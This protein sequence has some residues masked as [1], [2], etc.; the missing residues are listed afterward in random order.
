MATLY[1]TEQ[2]SVLGKEG[3]R[4]VVRKDDE[5]LADVPIIKID[6]VV[7]FGNVSLSTPA[8]GLLMARDVDVV[9]LSL[10]GRYKG[11]LTGPG[12]GNGALRQAQYRRSLD[13]DFALRTARAIVRAKLLNQ[14]ALLTWAGQVF[15][16][17][18]ALAD[19]LRRI[20]AVD[21]QAQRLHD[22]N[23]LRGLEGAGAAAY[24]QALK[25]LLRQGMGFEGRRKRPPPDPVNAMLSYGY[26]VLTNR[27]SSWVEAV[28]LDL[29]VGFLHGLKYNRPAMALDLVE[30]FR[31]PVV[32]WVVLRAVNRRALTPEDFEPGKD[33]EGRATVLMTDAARARFLT[34]YETRMATKIVHPR[35][36]NAETLARC[37]ELDARALAHAIGA[38]TPFLAFTLP[39]I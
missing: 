24:F 19:A 37:L 30:A 2:G 17:S 4:L 1:L 14:H 22:I 6:Q 34:L 26:T 8:M 11:R 7:V 32:D 15:G 29:Y 33:E 9:F 3:Q 39:D 35:S 38:G 5:T 28:G 36:G 12:T 23:A 27:L 18:A 13:A 20:E 10:D 21:A 25:S 16:A 31:A